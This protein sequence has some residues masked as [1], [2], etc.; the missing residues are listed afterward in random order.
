MESHSVCPEHTLTCL[1]VDLMFYHY[2]SVSSRIQEGHGATD[3][4]GHLIMPAGHPVGSA[5]I[6]NTHPSQ[7]RVQIE[8]VNYVDI[9]SYYHY[10]HGTWRTWRA[11]W[12]TWR[13]TWRTLRATRRSQKATWRCAM[14]EMARWNTAIRDAS[15]ILKQHLLN[16]LCL[17][18]IASVI[19]KLQL[20]IPNTQYWFNTGPLTATLAQNWKI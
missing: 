9:A 14:L 6:F 2:P 16:V 8:S 11:T 13:A 10:V 18:R 19:L 7:L 12:R 15:P 20:S 1:S 4:W 17:N 5:G 3:H